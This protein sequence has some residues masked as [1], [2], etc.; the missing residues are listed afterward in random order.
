MRLVISLGNTHTK[1]AYGT[2]D[3]WAISGLLSVNDMDFLEQE[4]PP[5]EEAWVASVNPFRISDLERVLH[6][7]LRLIQWTPALDLRSRYTDP[8]TMGAD[9]LCNALAL[10]RGSLPAVAVDGGTAITLTAVSDFGIEGGAIFP[11]YGLMA[12]ALDKGTATLPEVRLEP[13]NSFMGRST[14]QAIQAGI[15]ATVI[16]G[17]K[18]LIESY[19]GQLGKSRIVFTGGSGQALHNSLGFGEFRQDLTLDGIYEAAE[20][21]A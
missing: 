1:I 16:G 11:G 8:T 20:R 17:V 2:P 19:E 21:M 5:G 12:V 7:P 15:H 14:E 10:S 4:P 18:A 6:R 3:H 13:V 9:R